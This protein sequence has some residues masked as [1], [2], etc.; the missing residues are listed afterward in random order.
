MINCKKQNMLA[1]NLGR[2]YRLMPYLPLS[3]SIILQFS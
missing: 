1:F 2:C 3:F